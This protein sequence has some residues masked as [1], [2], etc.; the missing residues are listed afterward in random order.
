MAEENNTREERSRPS[1]RLRLAVAAAA[2]AVVVTVPAA[3]VVGSLNA[4]VS[5]QQGA[6]QELHQQNAERDAVIAGAEE[7]VRQLLR[8]YADGVYA[9]A[10]DYFS[11]SA[12]Y[13]SQQLSLD[14]GPT[15]GE[16][17]LSLRDAAA[18]VLQDNASRTEPGVA[19]YL[20]R[21]P[22]HGNQID[23]QRRRG[24]SQTCIPWSR[25]GAGAEPRSRT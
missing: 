4:K 21:L 7:H 14:G 3:A 25:R 6:L 22:E 18:A 12:Q 20:Y 23:H 1:M 2:G 19:D 11:E 10:A 24:P 9:A 8:T 13:Q 17:G 16:R 15:L 5:T